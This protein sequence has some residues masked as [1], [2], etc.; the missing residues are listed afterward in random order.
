MG[1]NDVCTSCSP[2]RRHLGGPQ[3]CP[4]G[5]RLEQLSSS[6]LCWGDVLALSEALWSWLRFGSLD[7]F[8]CV[9]LVLSSVVPGLLRI[10][11]SVCRG[12]SR[13]LGWLYSILYFFDFS[14]S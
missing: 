5:G 3:S 1:G 4:G 2:W 13:A 12:L 11:G 8:G 10:G 6:S 7:V 14:S 9:P